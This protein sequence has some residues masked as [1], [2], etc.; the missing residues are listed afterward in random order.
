[1]H[2]H[3]EGMIT[4]LTSFPVSSLIVEVFRIVYTRCGCIYVDCIYKMWIQ[5][6]D[7]KCGLHIQDVDAYTECGHLGW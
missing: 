7:T 4:N 5:N 3:N 1:M 6:M 2:H